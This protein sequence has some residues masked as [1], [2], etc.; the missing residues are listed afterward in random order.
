M[1]PLPNTTIDLT[2][3]KETSPPSSRKKPLSPFDLDAAAST[4]QSLVTV[5]CSSVA[6]ASSTILYRQLYSAEDNDH[7][8]EQLY[9]ADD[10][11]DD[12]EDYVDHKHID[13]NDNDDILDMDIDSEKEFRSSFPKNQNSSKLQVKEGDQRPDVSKL[14]EKE[15]EEV[16]NIWRKKRKA[17]TDKVNQAAVKADHEMRKF[18]FDTREEALGDDSTKLCPMPVVNASRLSAGHVF[19]L[20]NTLLLR[21]VEEANLRRVKIKVMRMRSDDENL[22][23][24]GF[25][26]YVCTRYSK[27]VGWNV[28][29]AC[30]HEG[31]N[32]LMTPANSM[33]I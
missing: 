15:A 12:G 1:A 9:S 28:V 14:S 24:A 3:L 10:K 23:V 29:Q 27:K 16:L 11:D 20:K 31:D 25:H 8:E 18:E 17:F 2:H 19:Q 6:A 33:N 7:E 4:L 13:N 21:I 5:S 26:F 22:I 32:L 30:C